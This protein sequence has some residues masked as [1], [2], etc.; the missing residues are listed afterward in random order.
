MSGP[1]KRGFQAEF[2]V[3]GNLPRGGILAPFV[4]LN[5]VFMRFVV[6]TFSICYYGKQ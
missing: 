4:F 3:R 2:C 6:R 5:V 1:W